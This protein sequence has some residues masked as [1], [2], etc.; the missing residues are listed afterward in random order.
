MKGAI[1][2][3]ICGSIYEFNNVLTKDFGPLVK[4]DSTVTDDTIMTIAVMDWLIGLNEAKKEDGVYNLDLRYIF[5]AYGREFP[6]AGYGRKFYDWLMGKDMEPYN[7]CG[8]GAAMR[9]SP[10]GL[11]ANSESECIELA[12][13]V[14]E[15]T[16]NHPEGLKGAECIARMIFLARQ[17]KS[18]EEL[19]EIYRH[20]YSDSDIFGQSLEEMRAGTK[21]EHGKE[22]CQFSVPQAINCFILSEGFEDCIRNCISIGGDSDTIACIAGGLAE[23]FYGGGEGSEVEKI[24]S[25]ILEMNRA[26]D[27]FYDDL[28]SILNEFYEVCRGRE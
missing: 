11:Y 27:S 28:D 6:G 4:I 17:G 1:I 5:K 24:W 7:S 14:T 20:Y 2:G 10:V 12:K 26:E 9:I 8:N 18:K 16:H 3:D 22:I 13:K 25:D 21:G 23:A 19:N 15:V